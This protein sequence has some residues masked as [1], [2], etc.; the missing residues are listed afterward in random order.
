MRLIAVVVELIRLKIAVADAD[1]ELLLDEFT[2]PAPKAAF[3]ALCWFERSV[4]FWSRRRKLRNGSPPAALPLCGI[5]PGVTTT[6]AGNAANTSD[7]K[8][9]LDCVIDFATLSLWPRSSG[10]AVKTR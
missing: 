2:R 5:R 4:N 6:F 3:N 1:D 7:V 9:H 8:R 10:V